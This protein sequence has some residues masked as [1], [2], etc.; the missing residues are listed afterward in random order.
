[1]GTHEKAVNA[2][3]LLI[4]ATYDRL[5]RKAE[6]EEVAD[7]TENDEPEAERPRLVRHIVPIGIGGRILD[8][9]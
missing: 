6:R 1:M 8:V 7:R 9:L 5:R 3:G 4:D 2:I